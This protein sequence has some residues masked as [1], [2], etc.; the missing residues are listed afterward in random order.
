MLRKRL[1]DLAE[2]E[3]LVEA[4]ITLEK[5]EKDSPAYEANFWAFSKVV[6]LVLDEPEE[7]WLLILEILGRDQHPRIYEG[8]AAGPLEDLL[9][10]H[11]PDFIERVEIQAKK[12]SQFADLLGG[13]WK[14][15]MRD[16]IW[17]RVQKVRGK[18]W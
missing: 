11:G 10:K 12:D 1:M 14:S 17:V 2:R 6:D 8:L 9:G 7:A 5:A 13:V 15:T 4:Y 16:D 18:S 3:K